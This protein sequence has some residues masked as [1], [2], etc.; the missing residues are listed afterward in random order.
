MRS[1]QTLIVTDRAQH[2]VSVYVIVCW[3]GD[4]QQLHLAVGYSAFSCATVVPEGR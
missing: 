4:E 2:V 3:L 1:F